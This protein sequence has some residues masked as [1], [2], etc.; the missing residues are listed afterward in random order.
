MEMKAKNE[1]GRLDGLGSLK[2]KSHHKIKKTK[3][4]ERPVVG[5]PKLLC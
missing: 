4:R 1:G 5:W 3:C 2:P